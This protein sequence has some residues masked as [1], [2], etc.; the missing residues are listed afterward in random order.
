MSEEEGAGADKTRNEL[1]VE[2]PDC[3]EKFPSCE[4]DDDDGDCNTTPLVSKS[5]LKKQMK[6]KRW[7]EMKGSKR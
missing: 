5:K 6:R 4:K 2:S 1:S 3:C 7:E